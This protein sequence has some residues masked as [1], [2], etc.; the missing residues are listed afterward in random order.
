MS[1]QENIFET[2]VCMRCQKWSNGVQLFFCPFSGRIQN[3]TRNPKFEVT[4]VSA[5]ESSG[6]T[7]GGK[8]GTALAY[9]CLSVFLLTVYVC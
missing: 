6:A 8:S 2:F 5:G 9:L 3:E 7:S 1:K 4:G